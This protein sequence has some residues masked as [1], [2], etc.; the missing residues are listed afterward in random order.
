MQKLP[1]QY[2]DLSHV[3]RHFFDYEFKDSEKLI[4][5]MRHSSFVHDE[6][7]DKGLSNERLEF[8]GDALIDL[9]VSERLYASLSSEDE[10]VLSQVRSALVNESKMFEFNEF[11]EL[12]KYLIL[13]FGEEKN[14]GRSRSKNLCRQFEA[15]LGA[16]FIDS[17]Y[18]ES[19]KSLLYFFDVFEKEND[20]PLFDK[21]IL[22]RF[23]F[24]SQLQE[25]TM[26]EFKVVPRYKL[27]KVNEENF[28]ATLFIFDKKVD[29][30]FGK[31]KKVAQKKVAQKVLENEAW[32][33]LGDKNVSN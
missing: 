4:H 28:K 14:G 33:K 13:G 31:S 5:S 2:E 27:E 8:L 1:W 7:M 21:K 25:I 32:K 16:M 26:K 10:G 19:K 18:E 11:L 9:V 20:E 12:S 6:G 30:A 23:D 24:K 17:N 15:L 22:Q 3:V 29:Y